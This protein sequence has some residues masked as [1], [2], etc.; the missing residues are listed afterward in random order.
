MK[1]IYNKRFY[2]SQSPGSKRS[3][4]VVVPILMN[5]LHPKSVVD[6]GCGIGTW[7]SVFQEYGVENILGI[8]GEYVNREKLLIPDNCFLPMDL[9]NPHFLPDIRF[10]LALCL[11][12]AEHIPESSAEK[13]IRFVTKL[14]P[15]VFFSAAIPGQGGAGHVNE[16]WQDYWV[17]L[18]EKE[19][20]CVMDIIREKI[21][22]NIHVEPW[23]CQ[24]SFIYVQSSK[25]EFYPPIIEA[26]KSTSLPLRL[27]HPELF[28]RFTSLEYVSSGRLIYEIVI[29]AKRKIARRFI[30]S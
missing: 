12:V 11:E 26:N 5:L 10:D 18:F 16:Q 19:G 28:Q 3:A 25:I 23:Y 21:W 22:S 7:L 17:N 4:S 24:N 1:L 13:L 2:D 27:V 20:Y 29:R 14:A 6:V 30:K 8:D 9:S 15:V